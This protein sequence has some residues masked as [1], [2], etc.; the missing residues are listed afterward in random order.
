MD[1]L[2]CQ[3]QEHGDDDGSLERLAEDDEKYGHGEEVFPHFLRSTGCQRGGWEGAG[4]RAVRAVH[5]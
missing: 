5:K 3:P 2:L 1:D 4:K